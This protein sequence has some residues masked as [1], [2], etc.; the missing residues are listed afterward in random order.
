MDP[1]MLIGFLIRD[2]ADW[3]AWKR[4]VTETVGKP[5]IHVAAHEPTFSAAGEEREGAIDEVQAFDEEEDEDEG[6]A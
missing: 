6:L 2:E 1:S 3:G 5:I 4:G